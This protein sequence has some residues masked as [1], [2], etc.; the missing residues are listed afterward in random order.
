[1]KLKLLFGVALLA[2]VLPACGKHKSPNFVFMPDMAYSPAYEAQEKGV[3]TPPVEGTIARGLAEA[4]LDN[5]LTRSRAN[6]IRGK[7]LFNTYCMVCHGK[8]GEGDGSVVPQ[9][10]RPPSLQ[11]SRVKGFKDGRIYHI[12]TDGQ[13]LMPSYASQIARKD[14]WAIAHYIRVLHRAKNPSAAD[15]EAIK[16]W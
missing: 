4:N 10:P 7:E 11:S 8:Y 15:L 5:P 13:N 16:K 12:I 2:A 1:M 6:L 9:Y 3:M 14:R